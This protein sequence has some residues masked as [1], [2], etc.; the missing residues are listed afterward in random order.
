M[1]IELNENE[2]QVL[3]NL[4]DVAVKAAGIQAAES[5]L[6]FVKKIQ[7]AKQPPAPEEN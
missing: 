4:L 3:L 5:A 6:H 1:Q 2:A 7:D